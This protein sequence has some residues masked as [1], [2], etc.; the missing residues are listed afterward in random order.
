MKILMIHDTLDSE[1]G[2]EVLYKDYLNQLN[3]LKHDAYSFS[4]TRQCGQG[5]PNF[6]LPESKIFLKRALEKIFFNL[7]AYTTIKS[8]VRQTNPDIIHIHHNFLY[9]VFCRKNR[10]SPSCLC[11]VRLYLKSK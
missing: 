4:F 2:A 3:K 11:T 5:L 7:K 1:G 10:F 6:K 9:P 8:L